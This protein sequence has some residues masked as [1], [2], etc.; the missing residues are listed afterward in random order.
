MKLWVIYLAFAGLGAASF[1]FFFSVVC[2]CS[3]W[4]LSKSFLSGQTPFPGLMARENRPV[5]GVY[6]FFFVC[7]HWHFQAAGFSSTWSGIFD[8]TRKP[9]ELI[10]SSSGHW[11]S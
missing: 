1:L 2:G 4:L 5:I 7:A 3:G 8:A 10:T 9:R 11:G 6:I